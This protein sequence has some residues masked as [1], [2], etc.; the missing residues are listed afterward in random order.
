MRRILFLFIMSIGSI[1]AREENEVQHVV[2]G[3]LAL[4]TSQQPS[5]LFA[6]GQNMVGKG[7]MQLLGTVDY[8]C[9]KNKNLVEVIPAILYGVSDTLSLFF[10]APTAAYFELN[11]A[12]SSGIE[13]IFLQAEYAFYNSDHGRYANQAT[14]VGA[15]FFPTGSFKKNPATGVGAPSFFLGTTISHEAVDWYTFLSAGVFLPTKHQQGQVNERFFYQGGVGRNLGYVSQKWLLTLML[16]FTATYS[17]KARIAGQVVPGDE[18]GNRCWL[19]PSIWFATQKFI[20]QAGIIAPFT[21]PSRC[22]NPNKDGYFT[23]L[24][25]RWKFN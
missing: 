18:G 5:P 3:N 11:G 13:D 14:V 15:L 21:Q 1:Y 24:T 10:N 25:L 2:E 16:E 12:R 8:A 23:A 19:G 22:T 7:T 4:P 6:F 9:G 17:K 20:L